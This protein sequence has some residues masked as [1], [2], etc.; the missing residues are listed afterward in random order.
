MQQVFAAGSMPINMGSRATLTG[1]PT[2][3]KN[4]S[5]RIPTF[6]LPPLCFRGQRGWAC[7]LALISAKQKSISLLKPG[8]SLAIGSQSAPQDVIK[9]YGAAPEIY[10]AEVNYWVCNIAVDLIKNQPKLGLFFVHTT[11]YPMHRYPPNAPESR[12]HLAKI[13]SLLQQAADADPDMAFII[14]PDH[15]MNAKSTVVDL[16]LCLAGRGTPVKIAMS[17]ER[18]QYPKHHGGH[19]GTAFV[20]LKSPQDADRVIE[21]L[22][23]SRASKKC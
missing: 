14:C 13:D 6:S 3:M 23:R 17:A 15:G 12:G 18:D 22:N 20:Y 19:G 2:A 8:T 11:D 9:K 4:S 1:M 16:N 5:C 7:A 21:C 10:S